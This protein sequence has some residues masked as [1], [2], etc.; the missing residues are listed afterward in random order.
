MRDSQSI[1]M[2]I[3]NRQTIIKHKDNHKYDLILQSTR[4][5]TQ[6]SLM[7]LQN[8]PHPFVTFH[9]TTFINF[10]QN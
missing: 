9:N 7:H 1:D 3:Y 2:F 5:P 10:P 8:F 4:N 6:Y